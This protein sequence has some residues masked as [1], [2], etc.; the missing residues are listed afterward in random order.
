[1]GLA[2][3]MGDSYVTVVTIIAVHVAKSKEIM[4]SLGK[5]PKC[6]YILYLFLFDDKNVRKT[7]K[8]LF[9]ISV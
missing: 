5:H 1:M 6:Y 8:I 3:G 4:A 9:V 2:K 7:E